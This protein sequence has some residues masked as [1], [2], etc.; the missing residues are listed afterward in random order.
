[1][2][3]PTR[4]LTLHSAHGVG[5]SHCSGPTCATSFTLRSA[6]AS[7]ASMAVASC[8]GRRDHHAVDVRWP[9]RGQPAAAALISVPPDSAVVISA[10]NVANCAA[11]DL[12]NRSPRAAQGMNDQAVP[13]RPVRCPMRRTGRSVRVYTA[14]ASRLSCAPSRRSDRSLSRS[15]V[16]Q[17]NDRWSR[18]SRE[19]RRYARQL[20]RT[21][22]MHSPR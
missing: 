9:R 22:A 20:G 21:D 12:A 17:R 8:A 1:M 13:K 14:T 3:W 16:A 18:P 2:R 15:P 6:E 5:I 4:V 7:R 11:D 19:I 10:P